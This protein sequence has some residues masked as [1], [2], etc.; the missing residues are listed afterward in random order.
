MLPTA[1]QLYAGVPNEGTDICFFCGGRCRQEYLA[2]AYV[3]SSFTNLA[4]VNRTRYVCKGCVEAMTEGVTITTF[5][6]TVKYNQKPRGYSW[7]LSPG[8]RLAC[9][10]AHRAALLDICLN[11]PDP[12]FCICL[13][14]SGQK[15]LLYLAA[16][17]ASRRSIT[18]TL[19]GQE[20]V[21]LEHQ[22]RD[23][24]RLAMKV[25]A[26]TGKPPLTEPLSVMN[27]IA[28]FDQYESDEV[29]VA[30][31]KCFTEPLSRLAAWLC[32]PKE[33]CIREYGS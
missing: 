29:L 33:D 18:V 23:R 24:L 28:L 12:P 20:V 19:E 5:D 1:P 9:T 30:W 2:S 15:H 17:N 32:P 4:G 13:S 27:Q 10:K 26:V 8:K 25:C 16:V 6:G 14:D 3:K 31:N 21:Y 7:I 22:L 11:P